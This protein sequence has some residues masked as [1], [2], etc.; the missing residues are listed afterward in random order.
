MITVH[1]FTYSGHADL[2]VWNLEAS[3]T[4]LNQSGY[5]YGKDIK[6]VVV[7]DAARPCP[8]ETIEKIKN[9]GVEY[10][11]S[12]FARNGNL[13]GQ[14]CIMGILEEFKKSMKGRKR[15]VVIKMDSDTL[16]L[17]T[18][19]IRDFVQDK[20]ALAT[21]SDDRG[22][23]YGMCYGLKA[24]MVEAL[25]ELFTRC[26]ASD[27]AQEDVCMGS[28]ARL[29]AQAENGI[30][31]FLPIPIWL[32]VADTP[33]F[34]GPHG[35]LIVYNWQQGTSIAHLYD[36]FQVINVCNGMLRGQTTMADVKALINIFLSR[37]FNSRLS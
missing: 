29:I 5:V 14:A 9:W 26:P 4:A 25:I 16:L 1:Y 7:D 34:N 12:K 8:A 19:W 6:M 15:D 20:A 10:R 11:Q 35:Q 17:G 13:N 36:K 27:R 33:G 24:S 30:P 37:R 32:S 2:I 22:C 31:G 21:A 3:L 28:R 18:K 23:F